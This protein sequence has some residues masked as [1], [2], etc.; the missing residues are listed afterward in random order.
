[1]PTGKKQKQRTAKSFVHGHY[2]TVDGRMQFVRPYTDARVHKFN[3]PA[4][5]FH[6]P[7]GTPPLTPEEDYQQNGVRAQSF[8]QW[9]GDWESDPA[10]ASKVTDGEGM[11]L[12]VSPLPETQTI[13]Q[14]GRIKLRANREQPFGPGF[15]CA[16]GT[17]VAKATDY[18]NR[19]GQ[20][21]MDFSPEL[22]AYAEPHSFLPEH[23]KEGME[24]TGEELPDSLYH[25][26]TNKNG[27][28]RTGLLSRKELPGIQGLGG[29]QKDE[30]PDKV[31]VTWSWP[32]AQQIEQGL[33]LAS[34]VARGQANAYDVL[35]GMQEIHGSYDP[36]PLLDALTERY[37][38]PEELAYDPEVATEGE[39]HP[40]V[41]EVLDSLRDP[42]SL[43]TFLK[44]M[45]RAYGTAYDD[46]T[47]T[48]GF[49]APLEAMRQID[50]EQVATLRVNALHGAEPDV[51]EDEHELRF[52]P[53]DLDVDTSEFAKALDAHQVDLPY[54]PAMLDQAQQLAGQHGAAPPD[55]EQQGLFLQ[56]GDMRL[57]Q[58][59]TEHPMY[60]DM[61]ASAQEMQSQQAPQVY[62]NIRKPFDTARRLRPKVT[63]KLVV[64]D[65]PLLSAVAEEVQGRTGAG[66]KDWPRQTI[67]GDVVNALARLGRS[68]HIPRLLGVAGFDGIVHEGHEKG[69]IWVAFDPG[70]VKAVENAGTFDAESEDIYKAVTMAP[71]HHGCRCRITIGPDGKQQ[72]EMEPDACDDCREAARQFEAGDVQSGDDSDLYKA[73]EPEQAAASAQPFYSNLHRVLSAKMPNAAPPGMVRGLINSHG[74]SP[75]EQQYSGIHDYLNQAQGKVQKQDILN[76][77]QQNIPQLQEVWRADPQ[78]EL[79]RLSELHDRLVEEHQQAVQRGEVDR[80]I[81][82]IRPPHIQQRIDQINSLS[83]Q[84]QQI[85]NQVDADIFPRPKYEQY[86][87]PGGENYRELLL[88]LPHR[89]PSNWQLVRGNGVWQV[90]DRA[91]GNAIGTG[92][93]QERAILLA[94]GDTPIPENKTPQ[95][96]QSLHW[97][98]PN[99][100][101]HLRMNERTIPSYTPEQMKDVGERLRQMAGARSEDS[102]GSGATSA[103]VKR[104]IITP[105]EAAQYSHHRGFDNDTT[106][107]QHKVL[108]VEEV[109]SDMHQEGRKKGYQRPVPRELQARI[110]ANL[111]AIKN[112][113]NLPDEEKVRL[114]DEYTALRKE[115]SSYQS[116]PP[117][118]P[119]KKN[120]HE[121]AMKRALRHA[122]EIG[123]D[124]L[125]W[126]TGEQQADRYDLAK[127]VKRL[128]WA[129]R[130]NGNYDIT[131][132]TG[133]DEP[134]I[135]RDNIT[136]KELEELVGRQIT[137]KILADHG[138]EMD[139]PGG[140]SGVEA[141]GHLEGDDIKIG[142]EGM[143]GFY[144]RI[145]PQ[146]MEK[147]TRKW[148]GKVGQTQLRPT[149]DRD[150]AIVRDA[151]GREIWGGNAEDVQGLPP[152][153][154]VEYTNRPTVHSVDITPEMR[155]AILEEGQ[156]LWGDRDALKKSLSLV[157]VWGRP[158][159]VR[160]LLKSQFGI[161]CE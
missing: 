130:T 56:H 151:N 32:K 13:T 8:K 91:T 112:S 31:S 76:H 155:R 135:M 1:M 90:R 161:P 126:T 11:P 14:S 25:V 109:Q 34:R 116:G 49:T 113:E 27:V 16:E 20:Q 114:G 30:A 37:D 4:V 105:L 33:R 74:I 75:E 17:P 158:R 117:D 65:P 122:A 119:F 136:P 89:L 19:P 52:H 44:D 97:D 48:V 128:N 46:S 78:R 39:Y 47:G 121:L 160:A 71:V 28:L 152:G 96:Y 42:E 148:G 63:G 50:P 143:K 118:A 104:G 150:W 80:R 62:L 81:R 108:H 26:T 110:D 67:G 5:H 54:R 82:A 86:T 51:V 24:Y 7:V 98:E 124:K 153:T 18:P 102:L 133:G 38:M 40:K 23:V 9:F 106:G 99:V 10:S 58:P 2:R 79:N 59:D 87:L 6:A 93:T 107:A 101:A 45:D 141:T 85:K 55:Q 146:W 147:Y 123:A 64:N 149:T 53:R 73:V 134:A 120:W 156:P 88:I 83:S 131:A 138:R 154:T 115:L 140:L 127:H 159:N 36:D 132:H 157:L 111:E 3:M 21:R 68:Q 61:R 103:G 41:R 129:K 144:D 12:P 125:T 57:L 137:E 142:G 35:H 100:L 94:Y 145:L 66:P 69:R 70:Q 92:D 15:Y 72:W 77:V 29:G 60:Q 139:Y 43:Y 84:M 95:T 22:P